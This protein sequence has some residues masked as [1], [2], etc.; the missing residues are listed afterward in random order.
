MHSHEIRVDSNYMSV[1]FGIQPLEGPNSIYVAE[2][3]QQCVFCVHV[4]VWSLDCG[5]AYNYGQ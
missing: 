5:R 2:C 4:R 3:M 1:K